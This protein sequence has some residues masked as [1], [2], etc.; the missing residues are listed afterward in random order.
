MPALN[1]PQFAWVKSRLEHKAQPVPPIFQPEVAARAIY[2]AAHHRRRNLWVGS[3]TLV[4]IAGNKFFPGIGDWYLGRTGYDS[5]QYD[6]REDP[7]RPTNLWAPVDNQRDFGAH[8]SF[9]ARA[10]E[11]SRQLWLAQNRNLL[12]TLAL[13]IAGGV[14]AARSIAERRRRQA[15]EDWDFTRAA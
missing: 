7:E 6:G 9:D 10:S 4:A 14:V 12:G 15:E 8:G 5:Q 3:S 13:A 1:T 2:W 11:S